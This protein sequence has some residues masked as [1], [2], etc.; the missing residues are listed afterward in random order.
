MSEVILQLIEEFFHQRKYF[1]ARDG[2]LILIRRID[3]MVEKKD[4]PF[5]L[6]EKEIESITAAVI[7]SIAWHTCKITTRILETFPEILEFTRENQ[8]KKFSGWFKNQPFI[9]MLIIP[10]LPAHP[11]LQ[12]KVI[13]K[14]QD[15]GIR[16]IMTIPTIIMGVIDKIEPRKIYSSPICDLLRVLKFYNIISSTK[17]QME[18]PLR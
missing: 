14:L 4:S 13:K 9:K 8:E 16:H 11:D 1:T 15:T 2:N 10:Q 3:Q 7:K 12:Q 5:I 18:L 17:E 6:D